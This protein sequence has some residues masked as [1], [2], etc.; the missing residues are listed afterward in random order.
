MKIAFLFSGQLREIEFELFFIMNFNK[1]IS[2]K[3]AI[4]LIGFLGVFLLSCGTM[5][6]LMHWPGANVMLVLS[7]SFVLITMM[8]LLV[9][10]FSF[11]RNRSKMF[12]FRSLT[13]TF[14]IMLIASGLLF[15]FFHMPSAGIQ[16]TLGTVIFNVLFLPMFF[17]HIYK[18]GIVR[19]SSVEVV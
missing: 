6:K 11:T 8:I 13:G 7:N 12:W 2:M 14:S 17:Y 3:K 4:F 5:F 16:F 15:K 1:Q 9:H 18:N 19:T 10:L